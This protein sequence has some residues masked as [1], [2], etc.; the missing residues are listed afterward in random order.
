MSDLSIIMPTYNREL[1]IKEA[2]DSILMQE[3]TYSYTIIIADDCSTDKTLEIA[4]EYRKAYPHII[5][6]MPSKENQKLYKNILRA[7]TTITTKY[8]C[9]LDPD[10]FWID[11]KKIQKALDFLES[12]NDYTIYTANTKIQYQH[13]ESQNYIGCNE[14]RTST[15]SDCL[16]SQNIAGHTS[17]CIFRNVVFNNNRGG[18][19][20][21][22][23]LLHLEN[24]SQERSF[25]GD[26]FRNI[27]HLHEGKQYYCAEIDSVY[28]IHETGIWTSMSDIQH[29]VMGSVFYRDM[30]LYYDKAYFELLLF[31]YKT[32]RSAIATDNI[33]LLLTKDFGIFSEY[34]KYLRELA[35]DYEPYKEQLEISLIRFF[36]DRMKCKY[37][38]L[39]A[40]HNTIEKK[41]MQ[42][43]L[44]IH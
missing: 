11:T 16:K 4:E 2:L 31:S 27:I 13:K 6:I 25:R 28:R 23:K 33:H 41:L 38:I 1:Y 18:G 36:N 42:K 3:T 10:D 29:L 24:P 20:F 44:L 8:F 39:T 35:L 22:H 30:W 34:I 40:I 37:K 17:S 9:V 7:Y 26:S 5:T 15:F 32:Y 19:I 43:G 14:N 12:H 21:P